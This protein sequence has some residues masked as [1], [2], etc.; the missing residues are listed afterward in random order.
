MLQSVKEMPKPFIQKIKEDS[1]SSYEVFLFVFMEK[2]SDKRRKENESFLMT[3]D[4]AIIGDGGSSG[5]FTKRKG[6]VR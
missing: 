6:R 1:S 3:D 2:A 4:T 5:C